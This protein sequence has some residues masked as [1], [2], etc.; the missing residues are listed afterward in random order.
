[1]AKARRAL[2]AVRCKTNDLL[3]PADAE[4]VFEG[5]FDERGYTGFEGPYGEFMY[6]G[7]MKPNPAFHLTAIAGA[8]TRCSRPPPSAA[9][10]PAPRPPSSAPSTARYSLANRATAIRE[11]V[12][13]HAVSPAT[14]TT[15][16]GWRCGSARRGRAQRH[17]RAARVALQRRTSWSIRHRRLSDEQMNGRPRASRPTATWSCS[18]E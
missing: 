10:S 7:D 6:Y 9:M 13:V 18:Q 8:T 15:T 17:R 3:V 12:V 1:M 4:Y 11:P 16:R 5:Y 2:P 14:A